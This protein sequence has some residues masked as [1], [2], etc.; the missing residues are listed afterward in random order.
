M[1]DISPPPWTKGIG[2]II[3]VALAGVLLFLHE[4]IH[5]LV[6]DVAT[7]GAGASLHIKALVWECR[8]KKPLARN[9]YIVYALAPGAVIGSASVALFYA[10]NSLDLKFLAALAFIVGI[11]SGGGDYW[12]V[13]RV[14]RYPRRSQVL[15][16]GM[17]MD[18]IIEED[19][20]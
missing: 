3:L 12:F 6:A 1:W 11:S 8:L 20:V 18:I 9:H 16:K 2:F 4:A 5:M 17:E 14:L 13:A 19:A 15:D 10:L 7:G